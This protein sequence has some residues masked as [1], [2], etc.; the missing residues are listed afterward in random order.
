MSLIRQAILCGLFTAVLASSSP[1]QEPQTPPPIVPIES[2]DA[3]QGRDEMIE[4]FHAVENRLKEIDEL[5]YDASAGDALAG[6]VAESGI[7]EL[8]KQSTSKAEEVLSSI[9]RILEIAEQQGG[10][11]CSS[12]MENPNPSPLDKPQP[13]EQGK[14]E[15]TPEKPGEKP[16]EKPGEQPP[17]E[18][19]GE[20]KSPRESTQPPENEE[21]DQPPPEGEVAGRIDA[22]DST[23]RWGDLPIH[24]RD[25][26][27]T[28]GGGDMPP[29]YRD[30]IDAY[31]RRLNQAP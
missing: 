25:L 2:V 28:E 9:D 7:D 1:A 31:Y 4:L 16:H 20:P 29:Q 10:G 30:W 5:L 12:A 23:E 26:F 27:R 14:K 22:M 3:Q 18:Q 13:G 6:D 15:Q 24:V 8:L 21:S 17:Q 19:G 11:S